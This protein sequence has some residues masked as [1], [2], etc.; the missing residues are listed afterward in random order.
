MSDSD[1]GASVVAAFVLGAAAG[2]AVA[3]LLSPG[4]GDENR[5][6]AAGGVHKLRSRLDEFLDAFAARQAPEPPI[7]AGEDTAA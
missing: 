1:H 7:P 4:T 6:R 3:L 5:A 2:A